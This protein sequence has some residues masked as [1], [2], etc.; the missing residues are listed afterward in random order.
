MALIN[1]NK[2][3]GL[4]TEYNPFHNGHAYHLKASKTATA[5]DYTVAVMSG[6]FT[7]RGEAAI[8]DPFTRAKW[9]VDSGVDL[10]LQLP[11]VF[12]T[13]SAPMFAFGAV[14]TL[15]AL[16]FV[17]S[18]C[19]G[20][21]S[22]DIHQLIS[23][24]HK[25]EALET[26]LTLQSKDNA[27]RS[28]NALRDQ[29]LKDQGVDGPNTANDIL[30]L[31][32]VQALSKLNSTMEP[33]AIKRIQNDYNSTDY[34]SSIASATAVRT[35]LNA[36]GPMAIKHTIPPASF[37]TL[38]QDAFTSPSE[39][40]WHQLIIHE[41]RK[42]SIQ[43]LETVHDMPVG[44]PQRLKEAA[45]KALSQEEFYDAI[46]TKVYT[47]SRLSRV[48]AKMLIGIQKSDLEK[49]FVTLPEYIRVLAFNDKGR[50]LLKQINSE[51]P[52]ITNAKHYKPSSLSAARQWT[53]DLYAAD[54]YNQLFS[55]A[56]AC[57][58]VLRKVPYYK[59]SE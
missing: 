39:T 41:L 56:K 17:D 4:I 38:E 52:I 7:Q 42:Q 22:G 31:A 57:G 12:S 33:F 37:H 18:L 13:A 15:E 49:D 10:V 36:S 27:D 46:K 26:T 40:I 53:L 59:K 21:E 11:V 55:P 23:L 30:G 58:E 35:G 51:I 44:L 45:S 32:Y 28:F 25:L 19:F 50:E 9:A 6:Y 5:C 34:N 8:A 14:A 2:I 29:L 20:S 3:V 24:S 47:N 43:S 54:L 48:L 1:Q 16:G